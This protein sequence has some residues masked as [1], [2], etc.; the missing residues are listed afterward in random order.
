MG[1]NSFEITIYPLYYIYW[2]SLTYL[3]Y[4]FH[5]GMVFNYFKTS[6]QYR[7]KILKVRRLLEADEIKME[8]L[9]PWKTVVL[10]T[11]TSVAS[12]VK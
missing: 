2:N 5:S 6:L 3:Y 12:K 8:G 9:D 1:G 7:S 4:H 10:V 11:G